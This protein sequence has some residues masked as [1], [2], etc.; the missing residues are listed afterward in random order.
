MKKSINAWSVPVNVGFREMFKDI[1]AAGFEGIEL[2]LDAENV[3]KHALSMSSGKAV[4]DEIKLLAAD[5]RL[6][7][8]GISTSLS[9]GRIGSDDKAVR[10]SGKDIIRKQIECAS[11]L[12]TDAILTAP[13]GMSESVSLMKAHQNT[14]TALDEMKDEI[15]ALQISVCVENVWNGFYLSPFD[16]VNM[17][18]RLNCPY[19]AAYFDVGNVVA[20]SEPEYWIEV[21]GKRIARIH[22]KDFKRGTGR[23][24]SGGVFVNLLEGSINWKK[25][26]TALRAAG[27]DSY[28]TAELGIIQSSPGYLYDITSKALDTMLKGEN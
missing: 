22:V 13:G 4:F 16:M 19:I 20:F 15:S 18:D 10:E 2:N 5:Y 23:I 24:N 12:G 21:L 26:I 25:V 27:Y 8:A 3:S 14:F 28:L 11:E 6:P 1:A 7:V 9:A 17:I